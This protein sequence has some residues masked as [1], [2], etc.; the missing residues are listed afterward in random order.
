MKAMTEVH[1]PR[2][3]L[4]DGSHAVEEKKK[5][6]WDAVPSNAHNSWHRG[7]KDTNFADHFLVMI[8]LNTQ[9]SRMKLVIL[10]KAVPPG[11]AEFQKHGCVV[12]SNIFNCCV[13]LTRKYV[14]R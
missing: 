12:D 4:V 10:G 2:R 1:P 14:R 8:E 5:H 6:M 13:G 3:G 9:N 7:Q 11:H